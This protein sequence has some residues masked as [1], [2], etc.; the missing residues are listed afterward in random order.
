MKYSEKYPDFWGAFLGGMPIGLL[1][2]GFAF[3]ILGVAFNALIKALAAEEATTGQ[4]FFRKSWRRILY[5]TLLTMLVIFVSIRFYREL[6][7][8]APNAALSMLYCFGVG[9]GVDRAIEK[10]KAK[11]S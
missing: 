8:E 10:L 1:F 6:T 4:A 11:S 9:Y 7:P 2:A 3:A 5:N